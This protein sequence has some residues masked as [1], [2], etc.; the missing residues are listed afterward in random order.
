[1]KLLA[2]ISHHGLGHL[3]QAGPVLDALASLRPGLRL[4]IWSGL[5]A[6]I[7]HRRVA[8]PFAHRADAA[9]IGLAMVDAM[10]VDVAASRAAYLEFHRD[11]ARRVEREAEWLAAAGF[12][13]VLADA[14]HLPLAAARRA[15]IRAIALCS[16][17]WHD[18]AT[19][20]L[21]DQ[22]G[23]DEPLA[24]MAEAYAGAEAFLQPAPSMP[25]TWLANRRVIPPIAARGRA[26]REEL[27]RRLGLAHGERL[28]LVGFGGI[29]Y[30]AVLPRL[31]DV[32]WLVPQVAADARA[33]LTAFADLGMPFLDLLASSDA[34]LTKVGYGGFVEAAAHGIPV[35]YL[36]RPDWPET[37]WL[38]TWLRAHAHAVGIDE[39]S[40]ASPRLERQLA[41]LWARPAR[42][43]VVANG[44]EV[45]AELI[46]R[47]PA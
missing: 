19:A 46:A 23:M 21:A 4:T 41:E 42:V 35:L 44:A 36:D 47:Q 5:D 26:R 2:A 24:R 17:N 3:A 1:M 6:A 7:L 15:G 14:A 9:D 38:T 29:G 18:I 34:L 8:A 43:A 33:D 40:L 39:E 11:W 30:R 27:A 20:Y 31:R 37:P 13:A 25:M 10:R 45:A 32:R 22:P 12:D 16:L 28:V